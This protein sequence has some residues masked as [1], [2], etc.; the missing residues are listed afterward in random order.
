M[1]WKHTHGSTQ[2]G[3][4][5]I[6]LTLHPVL[7]PPETPRLLTTSQACFFFLEVFAGT[8]RLSKRLERDLAAVG[9]QDVKVIRVELKDNPD[10]NLEVMSFR[11][12]L[13]GYMRGEE[14]TLRQRQTRFATL[15]WLLL[16]PVTWLM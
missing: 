16:A 8:G 10:D 13:L 7:A 15:A 5:L 3:R 6:L 11:R 14:Q 1:N 12:F 9:R 4:C 2:R